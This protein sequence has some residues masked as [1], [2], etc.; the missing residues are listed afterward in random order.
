MVIHSGRPQM[1]I[2]DVLYEVIK[3]LTDV[4]ESHIGSMAHSIAQANV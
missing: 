1:V 4:G 2:P 3:K